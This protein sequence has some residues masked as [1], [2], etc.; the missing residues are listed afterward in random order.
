M[1]YD[2]LNAEGRELRRG[3]VTKIELHRA[4]GDRW[5]VGSLCNI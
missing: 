5:Y 1:L 4:V 3:L 2:I